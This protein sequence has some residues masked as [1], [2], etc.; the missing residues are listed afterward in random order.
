MKDIIIE[1]SPHMATD[2]AELALMFHSTSTAP[3]VLPFVVKSKS[4]IS[5]DPTSPRWP[6]CRRT[7][8]LFISAKLLPLAMI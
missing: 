1:N 5:T 6:T 8:G 7:R 2:P 4:C 3:A